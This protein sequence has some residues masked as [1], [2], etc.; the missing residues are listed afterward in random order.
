M[1]ILIVIG[2]LLRA[3]VKLFQMFF[4][5]ASLLAGIMAFV[6]GP[7]ILNWIPFSSNLSM[8]STVLVAVVFGATPIDEDD[9]DVE[10]KAKDNTRFKEMWGMTVNGM[11]IAIFQYAWGI[12]LT[13]YVLRIFYPDLH[14]GFGLMLASA[15]W[16]GPGTCSAVGSA[17]Q[18]VGWADG[19]VVG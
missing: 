10:K 18:D 2:Q 1:G 7:G 15:F 9:S 8:Y 5:P 4:I 13:I 6:F 3:K 11:G 12:F 17:L 16:G 19:Q 14:E